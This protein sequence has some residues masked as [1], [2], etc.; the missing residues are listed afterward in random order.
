MR[1][2]LAIFVPE[3]LSLPL[4][5]KRLAMSRTTGMRLVC[6]MVQPMAACPA[7]VL[8]AHWKALP[9]PQPAAP[10]AIPKTVE[11]ATSV[12]LMG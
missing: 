10:P 1:C 5:P 7:G 9:R 11:T 2:A 4:G 12:Q 3:V 8:A 6:F